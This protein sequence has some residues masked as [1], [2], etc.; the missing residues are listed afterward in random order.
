MWRGKMYIKYDDVELLEFFECEPVTIGEYE[1]G[2]WMYTY[3]N[4]N[5]KF[6]V[7]ISIYEM[8]IEVSI[9]FQDK[10]VYCQKHSNVSKIEKVDADNMRVSVGKEK[11]I[12]LKKA[13]Q[14][15]VIV[16]EFA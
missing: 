16:E 15:G 7:F 1:A 9:L 12:I 6:V 4:N 14:I 2:N 8:Y 11:D 13:P 3:Q 10:L 5:F